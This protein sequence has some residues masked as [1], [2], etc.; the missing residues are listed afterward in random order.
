MV[1]GAIQPRLAVE[2][3]DVDHQ[4]VALP[5]GPRIAQPEVDVA[6]GMARAV[7][8][9]GPHRMAEL[10]EQ[11]QVARPLEDLERL[12]RVGAAE[13]AEREAL[14]PRIGGRA[15]REVLLLLRQAGRRVGDRSALDDAEPGRCILARSVRLD[16]ELGAAQ[17][18]PDAGQVGPAVG[19]ARER[20]RTGGRLGGGRLGGERRARHH[21]PHCQGRE[22]QPGSQ[23]AHGWPPGV[24]D[25]PAN[26]LRPSGSV[27]V[28]AL[29]TGLPLLAR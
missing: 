27:T 8:V 19:G 24:V 25:D 12:T 29:T 16:V 28:D 2:V 3:V 18:L 14:V 6:V 26:R 17:R 7:G 1:A 4:R 11:R 13:D 22:Q 10:V 5:A 21:N 15:R 20:A 9:D 23:R